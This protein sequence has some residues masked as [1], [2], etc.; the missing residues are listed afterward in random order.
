MGT[1]MCIPPSMNERP[2]AQSGS[3]GREVRKNL[4]ATQPLLLCYTFAQRQQ[5]CSQWP[6]RFGEEVGKEQAKPTR[7]TADTKHSN[8]RLSLRDA[9]GRSWKFQLHPVST[10]LD[11][12]KTSNTPN[13][14]KNDKLTIK[15]SKFGRHHCA[16]QSP[17]SSSPG[18]R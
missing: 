17:I 11:I 4:R 14:R 3:A 5:T 6:H 13:R 7:S 18:L 10:D 15:V 2:K 16:R 9:I 1:A 8:V 12:T